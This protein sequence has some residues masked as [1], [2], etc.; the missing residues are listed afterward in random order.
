MKRLLSLYSNLPIERKLLLASVIP[1]LVLIL[2][3]LVT[4]RSVRVFSDDEEQL[5]N[6]YLVQ[7]KAAEYMRLIVDLETGFRGYV[8]TQEEGYLNPYRSAQDRILAVGDM[9]VEMVGDREVQRTLMVQVQALVRRL[10]SEKDALIQ[11]LRAGD[12]AE[13]L[14]YMEQDSGR[15]I[16][17]AIRQQMHQ[18]DR[19]EQDMLME[20]LA[21]LSLDRTLMTSVILGG[22]VLALVL[23]VF[24]LHIIARSIAAPLVILAK[25]VGS[26]SGGALPELPVLER[27]DEIGDLTRVM[28]VMTT[29]I[30]E[31]IGRIEKSEAD[32][33]TLN[34]DLT[35]S[36]SKYRSIVDHA[37]FGIF[38][39]KG[40]AL[41]FSNRYN[42]VLAGLDP[43]EERNPETIRQMIHPEDR[44]RVLSEFAQAVEQ[45]LPYE[46]VFRFLHPD[47]TVKK[48]LSLRIPIHDADGR[49]VMYQGFNVD[50][51][52]LDQMQARLS[53]AERLA[54]LG[55]VAA[56][57]AHEL[58]NPLVGIGSTASVLIEDAA[59]GDPRRQDLEII[60][61]ETKRLDRIV[62]QI[63]D[64]V[65]PRPLAPVSFTMQDLIQETITAL[66]GVLEAKRI[67]VECQLHPNL[68]RIEAD[69]DQIKQVLLN[70]LQNTIEASDEGGTLRIAAF[71]LS[72]K[73]RPG[74]ALQ[75]I[76]HGCGIAPADLPHVF[77]PFFTSGK[78][79]GTGLGLAICRNIIDAHQGDIE[80]ISQQGKGTTVRILLPLRQPP[81]VVVS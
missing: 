39:T 69:R 13:V 50:I 19:L 36:E 45:D 67:I 5:S 59:P 71:D 75:V 74:M 22:G 8:L 38:T 47:G 41:V 37:P 16:M 21:R 54:T 34:R 25:T 57:I 33:L 6:I 40:M 23:M 76:D 17:V 1:V 63:I 15:A 31:H 60:L 3:S 29:Q 51:T 24:T 64:Y 56:G 28:K 48:V 79:R 35:A 61:R 78:R 9:L 73:Q 26:V 30:R 12:T 65:R 18:F 46:T 27:Q 81:R 62:N 66:K 68:S 10:M 53:R 14:Q 72:R 43:D 80:I 20:A 70:V 7:R 4:Y 11:A 44:N 52:I 2:L 32:L 55:Q 49:P 77:E 58:R 42:F